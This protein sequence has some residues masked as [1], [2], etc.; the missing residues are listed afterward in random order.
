M[1]DN[2]EIDTAATSD[3][4]N[5]EIITSLDDTST[6]ENNITDE[7][8]H[9]K[10]LEGG[11]KYHTDDP[12]LL[13]D[14]SSIIS[15]ED[16]ELINSEK[17]NAIVDEY[18]S[19]YHSEKYKQYKSMFNQLYSKYNKIPY[20]IKNGKNSV[21][22]SK[23]SKKDDEHPFEMVY[24]LK[25]P[26]IIHYSEESLIQMKN[27]ISNRRAILKYDYDTLISRI[28]ITD[29]DKRE[30]E[31]KKASFI[32][33]LEKYYIY[34]LYHIKI[35]KI[36]NANKVTITNPTLTGFLKETDDSESAILVY[37]NYQIDS[38][39]VNE[40]NT[41]NSVHLDNYN[42]IMAT[43]QTKLTSEKRTQLIEKIKTYLDKS[44]YNTLIENL[45]TEVK[46]QS[47]YIYIIVESLESL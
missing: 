32:K 9:S 36:T 28:D 37:D 34:N 3:A 30:F 42:E 26:K 12:T 39:L 19:N 7:A 11:N 35:N 46:Q 2:L 24:E 20:Q 43:L 31:K 47:N 45:N 15:I 1:P 38:A 17:I 21:I 33:K 13:P 29:A 44:N 10:L 22:V 6:V 40:I 18:I 25:K 23:P 14:L 41:Y 27:D 8:I 16:E 4:S 5:T